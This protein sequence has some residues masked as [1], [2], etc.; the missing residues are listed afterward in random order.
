VILLAV[1]A[2]P[3]P[4]A[5]YCLQYGVVSLTGR[6]V[7]QTYPG[8]PDY[9]S[10]TKGDEPL[11]IWI[12]QLDRRACVAGSYSSYPIAYSATEIQ[13]VL[14]A[15]QYAGP[16]D[17]ARYRYLLGKRIAVTGRLQAGGATYEKRFVIQPYEIKPAP[18]P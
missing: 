9:A 13:I 11:V 3:G 4:V 16:D 18:P 12:L 15:D 6:L 1:T 10:V 14:G 7:Q 2:W 5:A 8:A 17:Y